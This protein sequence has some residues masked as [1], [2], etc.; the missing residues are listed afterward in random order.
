MNK[1][2][3]KV[4]LGVIG[5]ATIAATASPMA[6]AAAPKTVSLSETGSSLLYPLFN[7]FWVPAYEKLRP[8]VHISSSATG[9]GQGISDATSGTVNIGA[10]DAYLPPSAFQTDPGIVN[11]PVAISAQ[12]IMYHIPGV[13][14]KIHLHLTGKVLSEIFMGKITEWNDPAITK[15]N[16]GVKLP[17]HQIIPV[18]RSDGSGDTF[19][20]TQFM[21]DTNPAWQSSVGFG[22]SVSWPAV[23]VA[24]GAKGNSGIVDTLH[25]TPYSVSYVG[26]SYLNQ[27]RK[28]GIGQAILQNRAGSW[29]LPNNQTI[30]SAVKAQVK[31]VPKNEAKSLIYGP[32]KDSYPLVNFEYTII[33]TNQKD[34]ALV[35]PLK[36]FLEWCI[37]GKWG[38]NKMSFLSP[39]HFLPLPANMKALS[40]AQINEIH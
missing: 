34:K 7:G 31:S 3:G 25:T 36:Q 37:D 6:M 40:Q 19:L 14:P 23:R 1:H 21:S 13:S 9:S 20:F 28:E 26:I 12:T 11:I 18:Y 8:Y 39:V 35:V 16:K 27:A 38:G 30:E 17:H 22:T 29:V 32:G 24:I 2:L 15:L 10:S 33:N 4:A 5:L